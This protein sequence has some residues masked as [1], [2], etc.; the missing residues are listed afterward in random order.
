MAKLSPGLFTRLYTSIIFAIVIS[1]LLTQYSVDSLFEQ[2]G[3]ND[4]VR[5]THHMY[6]GLK[7]Q[8][9]R[10]PP[11]DGEYPVANF[12]Y[13]DEFLVSWRKLD[14]KLPICESCKYIG[15][16]N[17]IEI[18]HIEGDRLLAV[19]W[20]PSVNSQLL[21]SDRKEPLPMTEIESLELNEL[22]EISIDYDIDT[23]VV[24]FYIFVL[25]CLLLIGS[26]IYWPIRQLQK[27]MMSLV[28]ANNTFG[29]G[30]LNVRSDENLTKPLNQ[31][32]V[33][34]NMMATSIADSVKESQIFAQAVPH[35][36]RTPLSRIQL[37]SGLLRR[38]CTEEQELLLLENIDTYI[39]D[40]DELIG[41]I[42][43]FT[44]LNSIA[45]EDDFDVYQTIQLHSFTQ[46]RIKAIRGSQLTAT[47]LANKE[48]DISI[49]V[50]V[51]EQI[52]ITTNPMYIRL[53]IDNL[54][55][56]GLSHAKSNVTISV[57]QVE[58]T[59]VL[60]VEDDG[61]G[62]PSESFETIFFPFARLDKSRSRK[63][64][65]LGLGLAISK[66]AT[67]KMNA[68]LTVENNDKGG[69]KF[70]CIFSNQ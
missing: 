54:L 30:D 6:V 69:A 1:V 11:A 35:E 4:F 9:I 56:N 43:A 16:A 37:A 48:R 64:G 32:A 59:I 29:Q 25:L 17:D 63:T 3:L 28:D 36:L 20:M 21:I 5:D 52:E 53:L 7:E 41:Q 40:I 27:Q 26:I 8:I 42:V 23:E 15:S 44:R 70:T 65:G 12:P 66:A 24:I 10:Q 22:E 47:S 14:S 68:Q 50:M 31:L 46:S 18:Y 34:F 13:A 33:S 2:D 39:D 62:I 55:K 67:K 57:E 51:D 60:N 49:D 19:Y 61:A 38:N 45:D 58:N